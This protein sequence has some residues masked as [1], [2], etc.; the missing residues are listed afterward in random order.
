MRNI[1]YILALTLTFG[2]F[3][4]NKSKELV[5]KKVPIPGNTFDMYVENPTKHVISYVMTFRTDGYRPSRPLEFNDTIAPGTQKL[6]MQLKANTKIADRNFSYDWIEEL[7]NVYAKHDFNLKYTLPYEEG[8]AFEVIQAYDEGTTHST[9]EALDFKMPL[10]TKV[11]IARRG[12]VTHVKQDSNMGCND[13]SCASQSNFV[14]V[15][16]IDGTF[17]VYSHI[18]QNSA[19]VKVGDYVNVG[20]TVGLSGATGQ[21]SEPQLHFQVDR[22]AGNLRGYVTIPVKFNV[23]GKGRAKVLQSGDKITRPNDLQ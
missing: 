18:K 3:S 20:D 22:L 6:V 4:Q 17:G 15:L 9:I 13:E 10:G 7:G 14:R 2:A 11:T 21:V 5:V 12:L 16:H 1:V 19:Q 23:N 8:K